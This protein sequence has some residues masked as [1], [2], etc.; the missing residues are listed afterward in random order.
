MVGEDGISGGEV[1]GT[2]MGS[3]GP[4]AWSGTGEGTPTGMSR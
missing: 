3:T 1:G 2:P 4:G